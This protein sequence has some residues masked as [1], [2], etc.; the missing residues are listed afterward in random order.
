MTFGSRRFWQDAK[1]L[2]VPLAAY[3]AMLVVSAAIFFLS[4]LTVPS[5]W[6]RA[7]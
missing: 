4:L 3:W 7:R 5:V 6:R 2:A 1:A